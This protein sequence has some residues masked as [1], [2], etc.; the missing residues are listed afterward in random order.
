M[1]PAGGFAELDRRT[2]A[3]T[4]AGRQPNRV[5]SRLVVIVVIVGVAEELFGVMETVGAGLASV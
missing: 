5:W 2:P 3:A 1:L 4:R